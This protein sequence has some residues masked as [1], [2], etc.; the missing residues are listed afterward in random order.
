M[1]LAKSLIYQKN[2]RYLEEIF[3]IQKN[4]HFKVLNDKHLM[5]DSDEC[6]IS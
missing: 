6:N 2:L 4:S 1:I 5:S 3:I